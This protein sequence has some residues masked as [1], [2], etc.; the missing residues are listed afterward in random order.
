LGH[1]VCPHEASHDESESFCHVFCHVSAA[2][3]LSQ[4]MPSLTLF[5]SVHFSVFISS[6]GVSWQTIKNVN[7]KS[8][9]SLK[10]HRAALISVLLAL[11]QTPVFTL[12]DHGYGASVSRG[13][14]VY[15][16]AVKPVPNYTA[17]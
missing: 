2:F 13:V 8:F 5:Q 16:P 9:P 11:S 4:R 15:V 17:W 3:M 10:A 12:R 6:F 1:G 14:P 7:V